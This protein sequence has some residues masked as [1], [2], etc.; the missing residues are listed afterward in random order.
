LLAV[1]RRDDHASV[2]SRVTTMAAR[3]PHFEHRSFGGLSM[4]A[5]TKP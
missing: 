3:D 4:N 5:L 2:R 1:P